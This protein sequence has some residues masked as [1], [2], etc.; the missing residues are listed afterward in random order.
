[1]SA[2]MTFRTAMAISAVGI[3]ALTIHPTQAF[4]PPPADQ[5]A[6]SEAIQPEPTKPLSKTITR[7]LEYLISQQN[8][9][10]GWGQGGG[11]RVNTQGQGRVTG[12][13]VSDPQDL[14][15]T[16]IA[17]LA[18]IRAGNTPQHGPYA[19]QVALAAALIC[20]YVERSD[21]DS[22]YATDV[23]DTQLQSKIG[24]YVDTFLAG[25]VLTELKDNMP[26][27]GSD[28]RVAAAL[29]KTIRKIETHQDQ[30]GNF[31]GN[32]GWASVLSQ[33]VCSKFI[34][35]A[36]QAEVAVKVNVL[37][38]DFNGS[39]ASL[40]LKTGEFSGKRPATSAPAF[41][42]TP[43]DGTRFS[44]EVAGV[45]GGL[46]AGR[47]APS[48]AGVDLYYVASNASRIYDLGNTTVVMEQR[49]RNVLKDLDATEEAVAQAKRELKTIDDVRLAQKAAVDGLVTRL[50]DKNFVAGFGNKGGEEFLSYMNIAEMLA[51][52]GGPEW[53]K[54]NNSISDNL[55]RVQNQDG[56]WS[57]QHCIT[58]R[59]FCTS[60][61]L[62]T[63]MADRAPV[64]LAAKDP[65]S[66]SE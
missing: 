29:E 9:R 43:A 63:L 11:W 14:G 26:P 22:L 13:N 42:L 56:S 15:N 47:T 66:Q 53:E 33:A 55:G 23:R 60:A 37:E 24:Q 39:V 12:E 48:D 59:T 5:A 19:K 34:N 7:G 21:E 62:L 25:L 61:A 4:D 32:T 65:E 45:G 35:R 8:Y 30:D 10:G 50:D 31:A 28:K 57:G 54:W 6:N 1:M 20:E 18:L 58:G 44:G 27:D 49:A 40:D 41:A 2:R 38:R 64:P 3:I 36:A 16:C 51:V 17:T 52:K 46:R